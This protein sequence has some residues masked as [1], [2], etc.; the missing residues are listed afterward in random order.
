MQNFPNSLATP[1]E[2]TPEVG[3][4]ATVCYWTDRWPAVVTR[5]SKT[6]RTFW[7]KYISYK[8]IAG[9]TQD[10]S[11]EYEYGTFFEGDPEYK[12]QKSK[13]GWTTHGGAN[14]WLGRQERYHNPSF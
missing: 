7:I 4:G 14:V 5:T 3:M 13:K 2:I 12:V 8:R 6:G 1:D 11:A 10:G 9:S